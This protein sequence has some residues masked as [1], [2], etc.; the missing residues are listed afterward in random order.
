MKKLTLLL[1]VAVTIASASAAAP[2][3][4]PLSGQTP[5][6]MTQTMLQNRQ[7]LA[8]GRPDR[9]QR[10]QSNANRAPQ[11]IATVIDPNDLPTRIIKDTP[12]GD[13]QLM[14]RSCH[15]YFVY[16][17]YFADGDFSGSVVEMVTQE[18][19]N[20]YLS[21][22]VEQDETRH[23][24][25]GKKNGDIITFNAMQPIDDTYADGVYYSADYVGIVDMTEEIDG[26]SVTVNASLAEN[27]VF[28]LKIGEDGTLTPVDPNLMLGTFYYDYLY[29]A[30]IWN[31]VAN[32][33]IVIRPQTKKVLTLRDNAEYEE[34][35]MIC[36]GNAEPVLVAIVGNSV[37]IRDMSAYLGDVP[38]IGTIKGDKVV[39]DNGQYC[40]PV[41][42]LMRYGYYSTVKASEKTVDG[43]T[44]TSY[45]LTDSLVFNYDKDARVLTPVDSQTGFVSNFSDTAL[46]Y[47][48]VWINPI[49][50]MARHIVGTSPDT[51]VCTKFSDY[52]DYN[53]SCYLFTLEVPNVDVS[54]AP[55]E[56]SN[57]YLEV[58]ADDEL[59]IFDSN[60]FV[61]LQ[62][63][64]HLLPYDYSD[65]EMV[66]SKNT[67]HQILIPGDDI[68]VFKFRSVYINDAETTY[69]DY[70]VYGVNGVEEAI[71]D[72]E[73]ISE[74][75][76]SPAGVRI[77]QPGKGLYIKQTRYTDGSVSTE[78]VFK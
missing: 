46:Y 68:D 21:N 69:S 33:N 60:K 17:Y 48:E 22:P 44:E 55:L 3:F 9:S 11:K 71:V 13:Y 50:R 67:F 30:W 42:N 64:T 70:C 78:K 37:Y 18:N 61:D 41:M 59:Y 54:S 6:T 10:Q 72:K 40:G 32:A 57:M 58:T 4:R 56:T 36:N 45:A 75:Y 31:D 26:E 47:D 28:Q 5:E 12:E 29:S 16:Q 74:T 20:V 25:K 27:Q 53:V 2:T 63:D 23:W 73:P 66:Y 1:G 62:E 52:H 8:A 7:L 65:G 38:F 24:I 34:W 15:A 51:P 14:D 77:E 76:Y 43:I 19:G 39:F 35:T 49:F